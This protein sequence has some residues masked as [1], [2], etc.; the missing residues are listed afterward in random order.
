MAVAIAV[1]ASLMYVFTAKLGIYFL[2]AKV[3]DDLPVFA[4]GNLAVMRLYVFRHAPIL[5]D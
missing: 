1:H 2:I 5:R 4:L 3:I